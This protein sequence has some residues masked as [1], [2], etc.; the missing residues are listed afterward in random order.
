MAAGDGKRGLG[1]VLVVEGHRSGRGVDLFHRHVEHPA[2]FRRDRQEGAVSGLTLLAERRQHHLHDVVVALGRLEQRGVEP[3]RLVIFRGAGEFVF[4]A[5]RVEE[6]AQH[7]VV[8]RGEAVV[9]AAE[10]VR[11]R[12]KRHVEVGLKRRPVRHVVGNFAHAVHVVGKAD[13]PR[14]DLVAGQ[15]AEGVPHHGGARHFTEGADMRQAG[16][17]VAGLEDHRFGQAGLLVALEDFPRFL[18][19]PRFRL[20]GRRGHVRGQRDVGKAVR[21]HVHILMEL[22]DRR[23]EKSLLFYGAPGS[24][25]Q[26][27]RRNFLAR[28]GRPP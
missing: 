15:H 26:L 3:A 10:R 7:G 13:Q 22:G 1:P 12:R 27:S 16:G 14:L 8:M 11:H 18:E 19:G 28:R 9:I 24:R 4:E 20:R 17:A 25:R 23:R 5:E 2:R 6:A 21:G